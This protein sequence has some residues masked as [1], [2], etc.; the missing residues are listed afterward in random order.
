MTRKLL[1]TLAIALST[2]ACW[3]P[4]IPGLGGGDG[5]GAFKWT[6]D[7]KSVEASANGQGALRRGGTVFLT[8]IKCGDNEGISVSALDTLVPGIHPVGGAYNITATYVADGSSWE[9]SAK[10]GSGSMTISTVTQTRASG[11]FAFEMA[12]SGSSAAG[13]KSVRGVFDVAFTDDK[14]C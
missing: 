5:D 9:A 10:A 14:I 8:G 3:M 1:C 12:A 6:V 13:T 7:G 4:T 11:S 2:M